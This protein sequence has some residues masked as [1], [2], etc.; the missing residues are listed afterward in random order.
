MMDDSALPAAAAAGRDGLATQLRE[1]ETYVADVEATG[2]TLPP[3][4][5]EM[6]ARLRE[7]V[8]ALDGLTASFA[9]TVSEVASP[10]EVEEVRRLVLTY[11]SAH[12]RTPGVE[13]MH[14][15]AAALPGAYT[16]PRGG[17][18]LARAGEVGVGCVALRPLDD[19]MAEV[20]RMYVDPASRGKGVGRALMEAL[21]AGAR[22]RG[23]E[24]VRLGTLEEMTVAQGLYRSLGFRPI[25]RYR[26]DELIDTRFFEL[27]LTERPE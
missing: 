17:L 23:Y 24:T 6:I 13:Y 18:W 10:A 8:R 2:R 4:A 21:I 16:P 11:A 22:A 9:V 26:P 25:E 12:A 19:T 14:A 3:E 7:L 1:L 20:K 5:T 27:S 15:D